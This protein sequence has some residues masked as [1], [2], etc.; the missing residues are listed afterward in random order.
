MPQKNTF[1]G[2]L[3]TVLFD[4]VR[5]SKRASMP[6]FLWNEAEMG[7]DPSED[8]ETRQSGMQPIPQQV[9]LQCPLTVRASAS[10]S[11]QSTK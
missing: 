5:I 7:L 10:L 6:P 2:V 8:R 9:S 4:T 11:L 1:S 3:D